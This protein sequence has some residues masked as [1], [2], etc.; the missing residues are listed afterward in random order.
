MSDINLANPGNLDQAL[1]GK[2]PKHTFT[3]PEDV[4]GKD[5]DGNS[6]LISRGPRELDTDP[7]TVTIR[8]LTYSEELAA[9]QAATARNTNYQYEGALRSII[10]ADGKPITWDNNLKET[11]F[12]GMSQACRELVLRAFSK[13]A[14]PT[15]QATQDFL[16]SEKV[17][18][19]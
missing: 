4:Y 16:A 6:V 18:T 9:L 10:F 8:Q 17:T 15:V 1:L 5:K 11:F 13:I 7:R 3:I 2:I 19:D 12:A 14:L